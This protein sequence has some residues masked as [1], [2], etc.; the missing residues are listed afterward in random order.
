MMLFPHGN[1]EHEIKI[2]QKSLFSVLSENFP[3]SKI[4]P[5]YSE[6]LWLRGTFDEASHAKNMF[7]DSC[8]Q[9]SFSQLLY[10]DGI[11]YLQLKHKILDE[12]MSTGLELLPLSNS[13]CLLKIEELQCMQLAALLEKCRNLNSPQGKELRVFQI[14]DSEIKLSSEK[15]L[16]VENN[17]KIWVK[18]QEK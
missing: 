8:I 15:I 13:V 18:I 2:F 10:S 14:S 6:S 9:P 7:S 3:N 4:T 1:I 17:K 12:V 11:F 16:S 5:L